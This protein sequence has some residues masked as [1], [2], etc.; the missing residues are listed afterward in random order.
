MLVAL[1]AG[2][3]PPDDLGTGRLAMGLTM[4]QADVG[5]VRS[6]GLFI[7]TLVSPELECEDFY[8]GVADPIAQHPEAVQAV[9]FVNV[10][11]GVEETSLT[12]RDIPVGEKTVIVEAYDGGGGRIFVGCAQTDIGEG[13]RSQLEIVM[14]RDPTLPSE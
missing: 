4:P 13:E 3:S 6:L 1:G 2:C 12:R 8:S 14:S 11:V 7:L 10:Q 9:D 5:E